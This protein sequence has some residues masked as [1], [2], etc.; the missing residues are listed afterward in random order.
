MSNKYSILSNTNCYYR[1]VIT[2]NISLP[3]FSNDA[4]Q[5]QQI[6]NIAAML[7][8]GEG[9]ENYNKAI[10]AL[11]RLEFLK[12]N[13]EARAYRAVLMA[14][15]TYFCLGGI[16]KKYNQKYDFKKQKSKIEEYK[17]F[18]LSVAPNNLHYNY[19]FALM[20]IK[21]GR[22]EE[23]VKL[24]ENILKINPNIKEVFPILGFIYTI[25]QD[26]ERGEFYSKKAH[27][28]GLKLPNDIVELSLSTC[29]FKLGKN[30]EG[31]SDYK[32]ISLEKI[33]IDNVL[34]FFPKI[35]GS[36]DHSFHNL[37]II[38]IP[39]NTTYFFEHGL[40]LALSAI[41]NCPDHAI[42]LHIMN[43]TEKLFECVE[44][45]K[46]K[47]PNNII[48]LTTEIGDEQKYG[49]K[50][51]YYPG[52]RPARLYQI[53]KA[54]NHRITLIDADSLFKNN[55][56]NVPQIND[57]DW[58]L[59]F[60]DDGNAPYW[61]MINCAMY[62]WKKSDAVLDLLERY[63]YFTAENI[64]QKT[65]YW[66]SGQIAISM[67]YDKFKDKINIVKL[68]NHNLYDLDHNESSI[69]W[70]ITNE[71]EDSKKYMEYKLGLLEKYG[72]MEFY[73]LRK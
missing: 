51:I 63:A 3:A 6:N 54:N 2:S 47:F 25:E 35:E 14:A 23:A 15:I 64:K 57:A 69:V 8:Q 20:E 40:S 7:M 44:K 9:E 17:N 59:S 28:L 38:Y 50:T 66:F 32:M 4:L 48:C 22:T 11:E 33:D 61:E 65:F 71:K 34:N 45:L 53:L 58:A 30:I 27:D 55:L 5:G 60:F 12:T 46:E 72:F 18:A 39:C 19:L 26:W 49:G 73:R 62:T 16:E 1:N 29:G 68:T 21:L 43:P 10:K 36:L 41:E 70:G 37:P 67:L 42:H 13:K 24:L 52:I 56:N 31:K